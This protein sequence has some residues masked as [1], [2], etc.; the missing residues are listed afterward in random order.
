MRRFDVSIPPIGELTRVGHIQHSFGVFDCE[1]IKR[2]PGIEIDRFVNEVLIST[3]E[4]DQVTFDVD[5]LYKLLNDLRLVGTIH[6]IGPSDDCHII[7]NRR[8][9]IVDNTG[10]RPRVPTIES[11]K[12]ELYCIYAIARS[13]LYLG[14]QCPKIP[15]PDRV[16]IAELF[17]SEWLLLNLNSFSHRLRRWLETWVEIRPIE[18]LGSNKSRGVPHKL[19]F[20]GEAPIQYFRT[21]LSST[22]IGSLKP[23]V[24]CPGNSHSSLV[25]ASAKAYAFSLVPFLARYPPQYR[26]HASLN[27]L[28][29]W[30]RLPRRNAELSYSSEHPLMNLK[31]E[32]RKKA[33]GEGREGTNIS[34]KRSE[35]GLKSH[36]LR[37]LIL[38]ILWRGLDRACANALV[39]QLKCDLFAHRKFTCSK[40]NVSAYSQVS[41]VFKERG[42]D[43]VSRGKEAQD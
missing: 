20:V 17:S 5:A 24:R 1:F 11:K 14:S 19:Y 6:S 12:C 35:V 27:S 33:K 39:L 29:A 26:Y 3:R 34:R 25:A 43:G 9:V 23:I 18:N 28:R 7:Y 32:D 2:F 31:P 42:K 40:R 13:E 10:K 4:N 30:L 8:V 15:I 16:P 22:D 41:S 36:F 38:R 37:S 21:R